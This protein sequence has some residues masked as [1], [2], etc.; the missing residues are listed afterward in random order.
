MSLA[1]SFCR[2]EGLTPDQYRGRRYEIPLN[3]YKARRL[4]PAAMKSMPSQSVASSPT[5][6]HAVGSRQLGRLA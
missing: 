6:T 2:F 4:P 5:H 1:S 3:K